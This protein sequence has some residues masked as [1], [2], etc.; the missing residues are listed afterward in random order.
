MY[1][2][3]FLAQNILSYFF[4]YRTAYLT[5]AQKAYQV[6]FISILTTIVSV[7][8]QIL[9]TV[10][11]RSFM[12]YLLVDLALNIIKVFWQNHYIVTHYP[13]TRFKNPKLLDKAEKKN[14]FG[15]IKTLFAIRLANLG[16]SQTDSIIVST[17][18]D[19]VQW[20]YVSNYL[21]IKKV[22]QTTIS[23][24]SMGMLPSLGNLTAVEDR[25]KQIHTFQMY[26]L[27]NAWLCLNFFAGMVILVPPL[28]AMIFGEA[29]LVDNLTCFLL[30]FNVLYNGL[31]DAANVLRDA[32]GL[33]HEDL[34]LTV[35]AFVGNLVAS[36]LLV[37]LVG[38]PGVFL[39]TL[40]STTIMYVRPYIIW[41]KVFNEKSFYYYR[42][43]LV[44]IVEGLIAYAILQFGIVPL[45]WGW[46]GNLLGLI[47]LTVITVAVTN[48]VFL[49]INL[50]NPQLKHL[51]DMVLGRFVRKKQV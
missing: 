50:R 22:G 38:L 24:F 40:V 32:R 47:L 27:V 51:F 39:G 23:A 26:T 20:G 1:Y 3:V 41:R 19:V 30:F 7:V 15:K 25:E 18:I 33:Y 8:V 21:S 42:I 36:V 35:A 13:E 11:T 46:Q 5:A 49:L 29:R 43:A 2:L 16:I 28:I 4:A 12:A 44:T 31:L 14:I 6:S 45:V 37:L 48:L 10:L 17:M 34:W 9:V